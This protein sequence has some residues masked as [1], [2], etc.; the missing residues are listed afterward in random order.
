[1]HDDDAGVGRLFSRREALTV[2]GSL[3]GLAVAAGSAT[4]A[5]AATKKTTE[6]AAVR[7]TVDCVAKP[8]M[9]EGPFFVPEG[10]DRSDLRIDTSTGRTSPGT[11]LKLRLDVLSIAGGGC[12]PLAGAMVDIWSCG[13]DGV[14][15]DVASQQS[16]GSNYLRGYQITGA[17]GRV[18]FVTVLPGWYVGRTT[19]Y[20]VK[21]Q[22]T[23]ADGNPYEFTSQLY[24]SEAFSA[25]YLADGVYAQYGPADTV[26]SAD[27]FYGEVGDQMLLAPTRDGEDFAASFTIGLDLTDTAVGADDHFEFPPGFPPS[28]A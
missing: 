28:A 9:T 26:N 8:E 25:A 27:R 1:M 16:T 22:T 14:Y 20:H 4:A 23:G 15:S 18:D 5:T 7:S 21:I 19:H 13:A 3:A 24:F 10:L 17:D 6:M 11:V 2:L 12:T